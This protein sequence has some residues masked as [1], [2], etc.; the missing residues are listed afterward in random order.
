MPRSPLPERNCE[1]CGRSFTWRKKWERD[2]DRV[3][4]CSDACRRRR[5]GDRDAALERTILELVGRRGRDASICPSEAARAVAGDADFRAEMPR[6]LA[7][8]RR[9]AARGAIEF[10]QGGRVVDPARAR[11]PV[12]LR[13]PRG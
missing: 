9:L 3:K 1:T 12:R 11:G 10:T 5:L 6:A 13:L 2:W 8:A 7:A 4:H